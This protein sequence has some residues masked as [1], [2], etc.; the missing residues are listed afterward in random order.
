MVPGWTLPLPPVL[1]HDRAFYAQV[2]TTVVVVVTENPS[3]SKSDATCVCAFESAGKA[4]STQWRQMWANRNGHCVGGGA[5]WFDGVAIASKWVQ[6]LAKQKYLHVHTHTRTHSY[7]PR[8]VGWTCVWAVAQRNCHRQTATS[9]SAP[10]STPTP[11]A[12][13]SEVNAIENNTRV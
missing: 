6:V 4:A 12:L 7:I 10:T 5:R 8:G 3:K 11:L 1:Q 2:F 9:T 13:N